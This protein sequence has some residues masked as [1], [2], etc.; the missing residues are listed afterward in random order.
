MKITRELVASLE[1]REFD[2]MDYMAFSGVESPVPLIAEMT[3][4]SGIGWTFILDGGKLEGFS[5]DAEQIV[6]C[7]D[8]CA[9]P[10]KTERQRQIE[11]RLLDLKHEVAELEK[12]LTE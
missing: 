2:A 10:R 4:E 8:I 3:D 11:N 5:N 12:L 1:F 7:S 6:F 9:L